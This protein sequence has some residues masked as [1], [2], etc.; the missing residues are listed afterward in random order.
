WLWSAK[1]ALT[2][3]QVGDTL[4]ESAQ[5]VATPGYDPQTGFGLVNIPRALAAPTP[6]DD[7]LEPNDDIAFIDGTAFRTPDP[8]VWRGTPH[9]P[10]HASVDAVED[11]VDVYRILVP[12]HR[13][14]LVQVRTTFGDADLF[15]FP[16][17]RKTLEGK[18]LARSTKLGK[19]TDAVTVRNPSSRP[20]RFYVALDSASKTS[21]NSAYT[22]NFRRR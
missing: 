13:S 15:V 4:R 5:D 8:Y 11:P 21:L 12:A 20:L 6:L 22:L 14:A 9:G 18:P 7:P 19:R 1:P 3:G 10:I 17:S 16:G 2:N